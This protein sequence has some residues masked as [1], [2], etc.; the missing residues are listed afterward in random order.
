MLSAGLR[1]LIQIG[2]AA[3]S[4]KA[5][6]TI[7]LLLNTKCVFILGIQTT[8]GF[9]MYQVPELLINSPSRHIYVKRPRLFSSSLVKLNLADSKNS[10][11]FT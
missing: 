7:S 6:T 8:T 5:N 10:C 2:L 4:N 3:F 9:C 11:I 1:S